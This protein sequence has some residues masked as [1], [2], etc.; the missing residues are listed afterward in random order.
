MKTIIA[1]LI[2]IITQLIT[3]ANAGPLHNAVLGNNLEKIE[4]LIASGE[5][6]NA[7]NE[8]G[9]WPLLIASTY[10]F[11]KATKLLINKGA[12]VNQANQHGYT[13]LH[14]AASMGYIKVVKAL[15]KNKADINK[16]DI[17]S[18]DAL[19]YSQISGTPMV[20]RYLKRHGASE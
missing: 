12:D 13:A 5:N 15:I 8:E 18:Y 4:Q 19:K 20:T 6:I 1:I 9:S 17:N 14:E 2:L 3:T 16:T 7:I 11:A 10:G